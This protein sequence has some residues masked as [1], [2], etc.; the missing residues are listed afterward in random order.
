MPPGTPVNKSTAKPSTSSRKPSRQARLA[1]EQELFGKLAKTR[2][3][4][5]DLQPLTPSSTKP[6]Q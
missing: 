3:F 5:T 4:P 1:K 6:K 2:L